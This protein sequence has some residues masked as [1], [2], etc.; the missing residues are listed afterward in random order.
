[1]SC[2]VS[3][4]SKKRQFKSGPSQYTYPIW[5][6]TGSEGPVVHAYRISIHA[7]RMGC[8]FPFF[9]LPYGSIISIH[10][11]RMG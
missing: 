4:K 11:S 10:A 8:D 9:W 2:E 3:D 1:M 7:S 6:T 5:D